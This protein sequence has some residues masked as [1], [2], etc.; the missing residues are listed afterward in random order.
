[1]TEKQLLQGITGTTGDGAFHSTVKGVDYI[2]DFRNRQSGCNP[3]C[4]PFE[5]NN[6]TYFS[7]DVDDGIIHTIEDELLPNDNEL[8]IK[9]QLL[10]ISRYENQ[11]KELRKI[12][13]LTQKQL[14][15]ISGV[16]LRT[17]EGWESGRRKAPNY[18]FELVQFKIAHTK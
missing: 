3:A 1:M 6:I 7:F 8:V 17:I 15:E 12:Y 2:F 13:N 11:W 5:A 4:E 9:A 10:F 14:A 18:I 16:P